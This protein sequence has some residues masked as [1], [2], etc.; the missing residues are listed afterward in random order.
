MKQQSNYPQKLP[1]PEIKPEAVRFPLGIMEAARRIAACHVLA[2][3]QTSA[4][5][6]AGM[7]FAE[8]IKRA[9]RAWAVRA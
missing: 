2:R 9:E 4:P 6:P 8:L 5:R 3:A 7:S 1:A